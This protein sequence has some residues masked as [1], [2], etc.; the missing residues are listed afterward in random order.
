MRWSI[1]G[2]TKEKLRPK[3]DG[4]DTK[5]SENESATQTSTGQQSNGTSRSKKRNTAKPSSA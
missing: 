4:I 5:H 2:R 3:S 1:F